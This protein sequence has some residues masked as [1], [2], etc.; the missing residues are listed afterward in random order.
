MQSLTAAPIYSK[1]HTTIALA[2]LLSVIYF[3]ISGLLLY[4]R[5]TKR[6]F[7]SID[8]SPRI[9]SPTIHLPRHLLWRIWMDTWTTLL[10]AHYRTGL[11]QDKSIYLVG[12]P[13][14]QPQIREFSASVGERH[15]ENLKIMRNIGARNF[16]LQTQEL[17]PEETL[18]RRKI[19]SFYSGLGNALM[20]ED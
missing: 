9:F 2:I 6:L 12:G 7:N 5:F 11:S 13:D 8:L 4:R 10:L 17:S 15:L 1:L 20:E 16:L 18:L 3:S 19:Y 14:Y